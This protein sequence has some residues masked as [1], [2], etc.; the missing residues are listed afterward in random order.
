[1]KALE[2]EYKGIKYRSRLEAR[3]AVLFDSLNIESIY[4]PDCFVLSDG[5]KYT[6]DFYLPKYNLYIEI[7][8]NL[9]WIKE[10]YHYQRY[11]IFEAGL[12]V[13]SGSFPNFG[14]GL[15]FDSR[16]NIEVEAIFCPGTKYEPLFFS[17]CKLGEELEWISDSYDLDL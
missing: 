15:Y 8:P 12:L 7:K 1:M 2:T 17:G 11:K 16:Q 13:L 14:T 6:P 10:P 5:K 3:W 9:D 4:E